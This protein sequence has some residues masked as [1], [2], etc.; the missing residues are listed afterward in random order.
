MKYRLFALAL[1]ILS[2][3]IAAQLGGTETFTEDFESFSPPPAGTDLEPDQDWYTYVDEQGIG[4]LSSSDPINGAVDLAINSPSGQSIGNKRVNFDL[5]FPAS[6]NSTTFFVKGVNI[7][8]DPEGEGSNQ[9]IR[10]QSSAPRRTMVE[11]YVFCDNPDLPDGCQ[12]RVRFDEVDTQG[13][14]LVDYGNNQSTFKVHIVPNWFDGE[15]DLFV[16]DVDDGTFP[17]L[18]SPSNIGRIQFAQAESDTPFNMRFDDWT[19]TGAFEGDA[20]DLDDDAANFLKEYLQEI[21]FTTESSKFIFGL[22]LFVIL[23]AAVIYPAMAL[24]A[25]N[26]ITAAAGTYVA[27]SALWLV[28]MEIFPDDVGIA[29]IILCAAVVTFFIRRKLMGILDA[30]QG[31]GLVAGSLGY[32]IIT[33]T[34]LAYAGYAGEDIFLPIEGLTL[35]E[36]EVEALPENETVEQNWIV[37]TIDCSVGIV[38]FGKFGDCSRDTEGKFITWAKDTIDN[39]ARVAATIFS[40]GRAAVTYLFQGLTLQWPIPTVFNMIIVLPPA[41]ALATLGIMI[42]TRSGS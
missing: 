11:F 5:A 19:I 12:F 28:Q 39:A 6:L 17:F 24:G 21:N 41:A 26:T 4:S 16:D 20:V 36:E 34:L 35:D 32:F 10:L 25:D 37:A 9:V 22:I 30:S 27:L 23:A 7:T 13:Q 33:S 42:I 3:G 1:L 15:Y 14:V 38:T 2:P 31:P 18:E 29:L 8:D 40:Y